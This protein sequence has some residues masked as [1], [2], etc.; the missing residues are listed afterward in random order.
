MARQLVLKEHYQNIHLP[1]VEPGVYWENDPRLGGFAD[2]LVDTGRAKWVPAGSVVTG[3]VTFFAGDLSQP[4]TAVQALAQPSTSV[5]D[6]PKPDDLPKIDRA[7]Y[8]GL[9]KA[10]LMEL[11]ERNGSPLPK[12]LTNDEMIEALIIKRIVPEV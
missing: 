8:D 11:G 2:Y 12:T 6:T 10:Q 4:S 7:V 1:L 5:Q 9:T 3:D